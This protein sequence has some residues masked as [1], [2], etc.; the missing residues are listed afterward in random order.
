MSVADQIEK[1]FG[2]GAFMRMGDKEVEKIPVIST[3]TLNLDIALGVG[4]L[5]RG[6]IVEVIGEASSGKTSLC[7]T[8]AAQ[9]QKAGGKVAFIDAEHALDPEYAEVLGVKVDDLWISQP[10][11]GE[12]ALEISNMIASSGEYS[13]VVVDSVSALTPKAELAGDIGDSHVGLQARLMSQALRILVGSASRSNTTVVFINQFRLKIGVTFGDPRTTSGGKALPFAA[14]VRI[15]AAQSTK[16][17]DGEEIIGATTRFK[18]IKNKVAPPF[19]VALVDMYFGQGFS[20][21]AELLDL[22]A[23]LLGDVDQE[24]GEVPEP[25]VTKNGAFYYYGEEKL[26][27]GKAKAGK[28]LEEH[29]EMAAEIEARIRERAGL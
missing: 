18:I 19:K 12:D 28:Y 10:E 16:I 22:G 17:K 20:K 7:L 2:K 13:L 14:S 27:Q 24:T 25:I 6:R 1:K 26:G 9:A 15:E 8:A 4:G 5:P 3:G 23:N 21:Q 11:N 29:P